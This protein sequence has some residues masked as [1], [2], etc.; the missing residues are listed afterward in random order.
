MTYVA[1]LHE[2]LSGFADP[3]SEVNI[4]NTVIS[5][6]N[7]MIQR[8]L[9]IEFQCKCCWRSKPDMSK[10][11]DHAPRLEIGDAI[12]LNKLPDQFVVVT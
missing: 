2:D 3:L 6:S 4:P 10:T 11:I 7:K 12:G 5:A 8:V 9:V 1:M